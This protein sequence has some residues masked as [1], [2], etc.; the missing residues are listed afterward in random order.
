M[1]KTKNESN[2]EILSSCNVLLNNKRYFLL[3]Y[4]S[5]LVYHADNYCFIGY[6]DHA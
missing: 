5:F 3:I 4:A 1:L 6:Q 2:V